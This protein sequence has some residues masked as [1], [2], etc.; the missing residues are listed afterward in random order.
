MPFSSDSIIVN[1]PTADVV[2]P[3]KWEAF[4][5]QFGHVT[6]VTV[7]VDNGKLLKA[8]LQRRAI[9]RQILLYIG[10]GR[11]VATAPTAYGKKGR[12]SA[13][14]WDQGLSFREKI[15]KDIVIFDNP[16]PHPQKTRSR[17]W[18]KKKSVVD[19]DLPI[20][21][22][23][24]T[25]AEAIDKLHQTA[26][27][28]TEEEVGKKRGHWLKQRSTVDELVL[29]S[30]SEELDELGRKPFANGTGVGGFLKR[31]GFFGM[32]A[33]RDWKKSY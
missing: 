27:K 4:F 19:L 21:L 8:M 7:A 22:E 30:G 15:D 9:M 18:T 10:N 24:S 26:S 5:R 31:K 2:D 29:P 16:I 13:L 1:D 17:S 28:S 14:E 33:L 6:F 32:K 11:P 25:R 3:D 20:D 23:D 12:I